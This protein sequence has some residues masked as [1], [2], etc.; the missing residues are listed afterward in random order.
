MGIQVTWD[1]EEHTI[2]RWVVDWP[3]VWEEYKVATDE[4]YQMYDTVDHQVCVIFDIRNMTEVPGNTLARFP[5]ISSDTHPKVDY[6]VVV[7][8]GGFAQR[9]GKIFTAVYGRMDFA[10]TIEDARAMIAERLKA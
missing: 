3:L 4:S 9:I 2:L 5:R 1:N 8:A 10:S 7:G 6:M